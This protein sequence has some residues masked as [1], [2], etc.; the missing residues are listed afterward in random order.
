MNSILFVLLAPWSILGAELPISVGQ[1]P[2]LLPTPKFMTLGTGRTTIG[3][4][5][6]IVTRS[7]DLKPLAEILREE[8]RLVVGINL[9]TAEGP[10]QSGDISLAIDPKIQAGENILGVKKGAILKTRDGAHRLV[11]TDSVSIIGYDYRAVAEGTITLLQIINLTEKGVFVP[12]ITIDDWPHADF[13]GAMF[14]VARQANSIPEIR[15][16]IIVCRACKVR[17]LQLHL[18]DDQAWTFPSSIYPALGT[19]NGSAHGGPAPQ[20]YDLD[21]LKGLVQFADNRGVTLVPE[22]ELPGHSGNA[23]R[24][25]PEIFGYLDP[26]SKRPVAQGMMNIANPELYKALDTIVGEMCDVFASSP[27]FHIGCDEVSGLGAVA[28]TPEA[29]AFIRE[30][31]L[32]NPN[33]LLKNFITQ[34]NL[35][36]KKRGKKTIIWEGAANSIS[37]DIIHM[38]WDGNARTAERLVEDGV[39]TITVPWN[40]AG[41]LWQDWTMYHCNGSILKKGDLVLGAMLPIW[42]QKGEVNLRWLRGGILKRQERTWGP[43]SVIDPARFEIRL[44]SF[45]QVIDRLL[46]GFAIQ[47]N[48][49][50]EEG[51]MHRQITVPTMLSLPTWPSLGI[52]RYTVDGTEPTAASPAWS[53]PHSIA[54]SYT[55]K[56]RLFDSAGNAVAALCSQ[57]YIFSPLTLRP[58]GLQANSEWFTHSASLA[59]DSS[60][61][62]GLIR[63]TL[64]GSRPV[65]SSPVFTQPVL[66][67]KT[68]VVK[69]RWF[70]REN[71]GRGAEAMASFRQIATVRHAAVNKPVSITVT[72]KL[73]DQKASAKLLTDGVLGRDGDWGSPEV[74][75]LGDSNLEALID[76]GKRQKIHK[77]ITRFIY[78]QE[79]GIYPAKHVD[80]L[81]SDDGFSF[82]IAGSTKFA[83][84]QNRAADGVFIRSIAVDSTAEGRFVKIFCENNGQLPAWHMAPGVRGHLMIDEILVNPEEKAD[85]DLPNKPG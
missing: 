24:T 65:T 41:T 45:N 17:Y 13:T 9:Q 46:Y 20:R 84:P 31:K 79:A 58:K 5:S 74:L 22:L 67:S 27:Y 23:C 16:A 4:G 15:R 33:G 30:N 32:E 52:I 36:V 69:A 47:H 68:T 85:P 44:D 81:V 50:N 59:I 6:R 62:D 14:D 3:A 28:S 51:L 42:E 18:T 80:V 26:A 37:K 29:I 60:M 43:D 70:D 77:V 54:D 55:I 75:R 1:F 38:T 39:P 11:A 82:K 72:A 10:P 21:E 73:D 64:D 76:L 25:M 53:A 40:L 66:I 71:V 8:I 35:M 19:R 78:H 2:I 63:Y 7:P 61:K 56:A 57:P 48:P 34:I 83:V 12:A 49:K